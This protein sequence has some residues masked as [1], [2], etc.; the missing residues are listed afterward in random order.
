[1][2]PL[3]LPAETL[4][5]ASRL[6]LPPCPPSAPAK[7]PLL[8]AA[9]PPRALIPPATRMSPFNRVATTDG[10]PAMPGITVVVRPLMKTSPADPPEPRVP[11]V[12]RL[13]T[14]T[15]YPRR[16][17]LPPLV[18]MLPEPGAEM[19]L[20]APLAEFEA[21]SLALRVTFVPL[22]LM[23]PPRLMLLP[24]CA[25]KLPPPEVRFRFVCRLI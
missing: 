17:T 13:P 14:A 20:P 23:L 11:V 4:P 8:L 25:V 2:A 24:A 3:A 6:T 1:M 7:V 16:L 19:M 9:L 21:G 10:A 18:V 12:W 22:T 15:P 5:L